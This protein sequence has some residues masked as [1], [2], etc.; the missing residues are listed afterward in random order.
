[1]THLDVK[2]S[3]RDLTCKEVLAAPP[4]R[5]RVSASLYLIVTPNGVRRWAFRYTKPSTKRVT[6][7][8]LGS[9][10]LMTLAEAKEAVHEMR[11]LVARGVDLSNTK[12]IPELSRPHSQRP[13]T[14]G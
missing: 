14:V 7:H 1:M 11:R 6:E 10:E 4:G 12:G 3:L 2:Q 13:P 8:G 5:H 9:I